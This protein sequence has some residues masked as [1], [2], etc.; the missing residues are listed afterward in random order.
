VVLKQWI[1]EDEHV[2]E[3]VNVETGEFADRHTLS[4]AI[5]G[6]TA[7]GAFQFEQQAYFTE[8]DGRINWM[9]VLCSGTRPA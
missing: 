8:Q 7:E 4:Y 6:H 9:R 2:D 5:R 1:E 3:L